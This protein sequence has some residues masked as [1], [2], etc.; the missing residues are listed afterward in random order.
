MNLNINN[1]KALRIGMSS[2]L[3]SAMVVEPHGNNSF[4]KLV[5]QVNE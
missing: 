3:N 1:R 2:Y 5:F 4:S